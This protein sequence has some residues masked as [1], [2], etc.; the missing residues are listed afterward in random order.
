M[1]ADAVAATLRA[2]KAERAIIPQASDA[3]GCR[4][5]SHRRDTC[6]HC[7]IFRRDESGSFHLR[8]GRDVFHRHRW[9]GGRRQVASGS[10]T[11]NRPD[12][13]GWS[14]H[15]DVAGRRPDFSAL[16]PLD[17][18]GRSAVGRGLVCQPC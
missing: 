9:G 11:P 4:D 12:D 15:V 2:R 5:C 6:H 1:A 10:D 7:R 17:R 14:G 13:R 8:A 18:T 3:A 16:P